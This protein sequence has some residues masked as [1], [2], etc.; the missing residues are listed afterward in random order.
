MVSCNLA[1]RVSS[2]LNQFLAHRLRFFI[3]LKTGSAHE[4]RYVDGRESPIYDGR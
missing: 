4:G 1:K 2:P 3:H